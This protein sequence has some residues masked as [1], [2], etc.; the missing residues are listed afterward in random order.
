MESFGIYFTAFIFIMGMVSTIVCIVWGISFF[1]NWLLYKRH[2]KSE[3]EKYADD[4][5]ITV[6]GEY[7]IKAFTCDWKISKKQNEEEETIW[8][9]TIH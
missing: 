5:E 8:E 2:L 9:T 4:S 1:T 3:S 6:I 7:T